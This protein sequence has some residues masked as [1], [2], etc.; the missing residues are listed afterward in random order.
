M[1]AVLSLT[2][3]NCASI[4][5]G[6]TQDI[7]VNSTPAQAQLVIKTTS[8]SEVFKGATPATVKLSRG[9]AYSVTLKLQ[10][11]NDANIMLGQKVSGAFIGNL[12]C[13]G[14]IGFIVDYSNGSMYNLD[15]ESVNI[16]LQASTSGLN[17][18]SAQ[19]VFYAYDA[20]GQ[21]RKMTVPL[22]KS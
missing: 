17:G 11:Y 7:P 8:G 13:G 1:L 2:L 19:A 10:G 21:L 5:N 20:D 9:S 6:T 3:T 12:L 16:T 22:I 14:L 15:P 4:L 18:E